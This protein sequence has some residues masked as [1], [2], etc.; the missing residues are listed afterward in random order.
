MIT[1]VFNKL[2]VKIIEQQETII[3]PLAVE[4]AKK[5]PGL[6]IE[7]PGKKITL[8]ADKKTILESLVKR[9]QAIFG[10]TSLEVCKE[11]VHSMASNIPLD[12]I[13]SLLQ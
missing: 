1:D 3:G 9:Y 10:Q 8:N 4:Q 2:V 13:P 11:I 7:W 12:Q 5:V 6:S